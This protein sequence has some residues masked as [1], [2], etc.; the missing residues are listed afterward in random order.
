MLLILLVCG[1]TIGFAI[2]TTTLEI[3]G[4]G[5]IKGN[6]WDIHWENVANEAGVTAQTPVID[7]NKT[8]VT[9]EINLVNPGDYYEFTVDA[10]N[11]GSLDGVIID[12]KSKF[13]EADGVTEIEKPAY[14]D[15]SVTP[16]TYVR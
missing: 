9:Y 10:V 12:I 13:Y 15:F 6:K 11:A 8:T 7:S 5:L 2:L 14:I 1:I 4:I 16:C 3:N